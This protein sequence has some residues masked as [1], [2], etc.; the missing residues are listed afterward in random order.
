MCTV[1][2]DAPWVYSILLLDTNKNATLDNISIPSD[3]PSETRLTVLHYAG[4][5][6]IFA[7][8]PFWATQFSL[9][10]WQNGTL[11]GVRLI[12]PFRQDNADM[13]SIRAVF[14]P[15]PTSFLFATDEM[16]SESI[17]MKHTRGSVVR[18][19]S[20]VN[21]ALK[22]DWESPVLG[23]CITAIVPVPNL[24]FVVVFGTQDQREDAVEHQFFRFIAVLDATTGELKRRED[25]PKTAGSSLGV[26][27]E[28]LVLF[29]MGKVMIQ[30][31]A[32]FVVQGLP[33]GE[34]VEAEVVD[35]CI[36]GGGV[37]MVNKEAVSFVSL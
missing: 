6:L 1:T 29:A 9:V 34:M 20:F 17:E 37:A 7:A 33:E 36:V 13:A 18:W 28:T 11:S 22:L 31:I 8:L 32:E 14:S 2:K 25:I 26:D 3:F 10:V 12:L 35:A 24:Q 30:G 27:R 4:D 19:V 5:V 23:G 21:G 15:S 16:S